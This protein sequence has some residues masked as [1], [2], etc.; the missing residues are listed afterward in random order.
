MGFADNRRPGAADDPYRE[1]FPP[2]GVP[3]EAEAPGEVPRGL[4]RCLLLPGFNIH[5]R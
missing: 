5:I 2:G 1:V 3:N 4:F